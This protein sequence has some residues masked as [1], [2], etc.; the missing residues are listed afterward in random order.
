MFLAAQEQRNLAATPRGNWIS[1]MSEATK[2]RTQFELAHSR[3]DLDRPASISNDS[4][5]DVNKAVQA[6]LRPV[7]EE[8]MR[9]RVKLAN[10]E[11]EAEKSQAKRKADA[12]ADAEAASL[13]ERGPA[14]EVQAADFEW[15]WQEPDNQSS[16]RASGFGREVKTSRTFV[17]SFK[18]VTPWRMYWVSVALQ[19]RTEKADRTQLG[20]GE[21]DQL[22]IEV[23]AFT[24]KPPA[25]TFSGTFTTAFLPKA[26][27]RPSALSELIGSSERF[28]VEMEEMNNSLRASAGAAATW[29]LTQAREQRS[30]IAQ[31]RDQAINELKKW[32]A[33]SD[34]DEPRKHMKRAIAL[35]E[36]VCD[37][38]DSII[39][40]LRDRP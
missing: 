5:D 4:P 20:P 18:N 39:A 8:Q 11:R 7:T 21:S 24:A 33:R 6:A 15:S 27:S 3:Y 40:Q 22:R 34:A 17:L 14:R 26:S 32:P 38:L 30:R 25:P 16:I 37:Y 35:A 13:R 2:A 12:E 1:Y 29:T 23:N 9:L 36:K 31:V 28:E 10:E 19:G